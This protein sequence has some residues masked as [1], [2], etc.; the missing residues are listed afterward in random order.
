MNDAKAEKKRKTKNKLN[1]FEK[2]MVF[3][4]K[5][6]PWKSGWDESLTAHNMQIFKNLDNVKNI[7]TQLQSLD[8]CLNFSINCH[9][10]YLVSQTNKN[11]RTK[12][13]PM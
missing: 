10:T 7:K 6:N 9:S 2:L 13:Q 8:E 11:K 3:D 1:H 4:S 12:V 5:N